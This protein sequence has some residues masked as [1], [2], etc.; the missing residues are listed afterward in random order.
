[1]QINQN[2]LMRTLDDMWQIGATPGGGVTRLALTDED[3]AA[4][5][6]LRTWFEEAGLRVR[7]DDFGNMIGRRAGTED[8]PPVLLGSHADTVP[9]GGRYDGILGILS[10]LEVVRTLNDLNIETRHPIEIVNWTAEEGS[11]FRPPLFGSGAA[12]GFRS[13]ESAFNTLDADGISFGDELVRIGYAGDTANRPVDAAAYLELH[14]EQGPIL[15]SEDLPVGLVQG[16]IGQS[17]H[18]VTVAG[19]PGHAGANP[20]HLRSDA[21]VAA[22]EMILEI[23]KL[24]LTGTDYSVG[25]V[26]HLTVEPGA[27]NVVPARVRFT[28]D[29]R[30]ANAADLAMIEAGVAE[31]A[32]RVEANEGVTVEISGT[33]RGDSV[34]FDADV[35]AAIRE[36]IRAEGLPLREL[37]SGAGHDAHPAS[38]RWPSG[39]IFVRSKDGLSHAEA[40]YS[41]PEDIAA[42]TNVLLR[43]TLALAEAIS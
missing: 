19:R 20:M 8:L 41:S 9:Q 4:R 42:G 28:V 23:R 27:M 12:L 17:W 33:G 14:I 26:G 30:C 32:R 25:T 16:I 22:A 36:S 18:E 29:V 15:E 3:R 7:V 43:T 39:M 11:R 31:V 35:M 5:N 38:L 10:A 24:A 21:L 6:L 40:E 1:M 2:R 34:P 37:W 13:A